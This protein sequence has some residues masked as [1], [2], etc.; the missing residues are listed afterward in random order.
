MRT[1]ELAHRLDLN[2]QTI[3]YYER[4][5]LVPEPERTESGYHVYGEEDERRLQ[6]VKSARYTGL[7]LGEVKEVLALHERGEPP[8]AHVARVLANCAD[9]TER[10][11]AELAE[12]GRELDLLLEQARE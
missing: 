9:E 10:R 2:A 1:G 8:C 6:F 11:I 4:I 7:T 5:G 3:R 12:F